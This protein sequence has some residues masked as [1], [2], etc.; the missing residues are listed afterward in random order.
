M[1]DSYL[2]TLIQ[3]GRQKQLRELVALASRDRTPSEA[4]RYAAEAQAILRKLEDLEGAN[5]DLDGP[6][7]MDYREDVEINVSIIRFLE[8]VK[9]PATQSELTKELIRGQFPGYKDAR[10][11]GIRVGR[12]VRAYVLGGPSENPKLKYK[13]D[14]VGLP[15]WP[16]K[17]FK[18][19]KAVE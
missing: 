3:E 10:K 7:G 13:Y 8:N 9:R 14:L 17:M 6:S 1:S 15:T 12:C 16:D 2:K 19:A 5:L 11:M 18:D 4:K